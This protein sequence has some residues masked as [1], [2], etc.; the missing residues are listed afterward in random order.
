MT[1][2]KPWFEIYVESVRLPDGEI[3]PEYF[4]IKMPHYTSV[5]A[6]TEDQRIIILKCYRHAIG[7]YTLTMP[8]GMLEEG[9]SSLDGIKREFLEETG[10]VASEWFSLGTFAGSSTK[11]C[12]KYHF[13]FAKGAYQERDPDSGDLENLE[14][15][16]W[17]TEEV[18]QAIAEGHAKS[19]GVVSLILLGL[20]YIK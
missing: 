12:G 9:E 7:E 17:T 5:F 18:K 1:G 2:K 3:V 10:Y 19:L 6:L 14:L 11:G 15:L 13:F 4:G 16:L 20:Q 8:G